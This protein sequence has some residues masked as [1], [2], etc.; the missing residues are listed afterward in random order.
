MSSNEV[1][2]DDQSTE[3]QKQNRFQ[4]ETIFLNLTLCLREEIT[5]FVIK[6]LRLKK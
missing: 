1:G 4:D 2:V 6:W 3:V 5:P